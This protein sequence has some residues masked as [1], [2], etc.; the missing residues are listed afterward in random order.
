MHNLREKKNNFLVKIN[1]KPE[2]NQSK[3]KS[4]RMQTRSFFQTRE[5]PLRNLKRSKTLEKSKLPQPPPHVLS[6]TA[7]FTVNINY[8]SI[9][10][11]YITIHLHI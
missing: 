4:E 8:I 9:L 10:S 2:Q 7:L 1:Q 3:T 6:R 5:L 11:N